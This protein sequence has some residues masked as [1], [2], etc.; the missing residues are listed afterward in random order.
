MKEQIKQ[1]L[2]FKKAFGQV[3][4][5][6]PIACIEKKQYELRYD[7]MFEENNE[8]LEAAIKGDLELIADALG[9]LLYVLC[10]TIIE[11]GLQDKIVEVFQEIHRSNMTKIGKDGNPI[12]RDDGKLLKGP[13]YSPPNLSD[14]LK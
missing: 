14:I 8:Y 11:H 3:V 4:K 13:Y 10:G 9:D 6:S 7:L 5:T 1:V 2:E 12:C